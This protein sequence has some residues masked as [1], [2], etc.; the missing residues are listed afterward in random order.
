[1]ADYARLIR[2][3]AGLLRVARNDGLC[4]TYRRHPEEPRGYAAS[5]RIAACA[6]VPAI[7]RGS[8]RRGGEHLR[9]TAECA[10]RKKTPMRPVRC[11]RKSD[12]RRVGWLDQLQSQ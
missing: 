8:P 9:M 1:M 11:G 4:R 3:T 10:A 5:R 2:P 7:L 12:G 6:C